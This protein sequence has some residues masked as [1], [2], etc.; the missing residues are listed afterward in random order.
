MPAAV[1][2]LERTSKAAV[3]ASIVLLIALQLATHPDLTPALR[4]A[5]LTAI[6]GSWLAGPRR[7]P[8]LAAAWL[9]AAPLAPAVLRALAGREG[10]VL[11]LVWLSGLSGTLLRASPWSSWTTAL[12]P[13]WRVL[14]GGWALTVALGW[15]VVVG[16]E[17]GFTWSGFEDDEAITSWARLSAPQTA[18]W[19]ASV[20]LSQ[21]VAVLCLDWLARAWRGPG[22]WGVPAAARGL[23]FGVT[24]AGLVALYQGLVDLA[25][26]NPDAWRIIGRATGTMLDA[27][28]YGTAAAL[29]GPSAFI[30]LLGATPRRPLASTLA[31][32][33]LVINGLGVW[34]SGSRTAFLCALVGGLALAVA[35]LPARRARAW[36]SRPAL[37]ILAALVVAAVGTVLALSTSAVGPLARLRDIPA[38]AAGFDWLWNR[39]GYGTSAVQMLREFPWSGVGVGAYHVLVPDYSRLFAGVTLPFDNAQNWWRHQ[40]AELGVPAALPVLLFSLAIA[41]RA[42]AGRNRPARSGVT[43]V[44]RA[45]VVGV[46]AAS[47]LGVPTQNPLVL[48]WFMTLVAWLG[49]FVAPRALVPALT[50]ARTALAWRLVVCTAVAYAAAHTAL[51]FGPL[52]VEARA[53]R[54]HREYVAGAY[55]PEPLSASDE[56]RWTRGESHFVWP[57]RTRWLVV[58]VWAHHP[59]VARAPV[60]VT[61]STRCGVLLDDALHTT[62]PVSIGVELPEGEETVAATL[63]VSRTWRPAAYGS[64]DRRELGAGIATD[65][66]SSREQ[67]L[68]RTRTIELPSCG[69]P[70]S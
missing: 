56:F 34:L 48:L 50:P 4:V 27:N 10:T 22:P 26:A 18:S 28:A 12:P 65:F 36:T 13:W 23:A 29:A 42:V 32:I 60:R 2:L 51:A 1:T 9:F 38:S 57:A 69:S 63:Q 59:D 5:A 35:A 55:P 24:A 30:W 68:Q 7:T 6:A 53:R 43:V 62:E 58:R 40:V 33:A 61:L 37:A 66:V 41:W 45:L 25:F 52:A 20:A 44:V 47:L 8:S 70:A 17:V 21:L 64:A 16:R 54:A 15:P 31:T 39:L 19:I 3:V 46:G 67:A 49:A 11:D 14:L